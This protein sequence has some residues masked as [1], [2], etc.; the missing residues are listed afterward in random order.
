[1]K[2]NL[3]SGF[4]LI[5]MIV[6]ISIVAIIATIT[7]FQ[8]GASRKGVSLETT[9]EEIA[10]SLRKAQSMAL[11]VRSTGGTILPVYQNG[12]GIHFELGPDMGTQSA[13]ERS[14]ILFTDFESVPGPGGWDRAYLKNFNPMSPC[15]IPNQTVDECVEKIEIKEGDKITNL[16]LCTYSGASAS[17]TPIP[18]LSPLDITFL[19]PNLDAYFCITSSLTGG[20]RGAVPTAGYARITVT[21]PTG[22]QKKVSVWSTGQISIE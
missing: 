19:R 18:P 20:C 16:E 2:R 8:F 22:N 3:N 1:M 13:S 10:F 15:G 6:V 17:C 12:F 9:A 5:E 21:S 14:Y 11:A 4:T 7:L